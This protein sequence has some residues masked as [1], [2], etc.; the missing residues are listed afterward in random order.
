MSAPKVVLVRTAVAVRASPGRCLCDKNGDGH[1]VSISDAVAIS[2][3][4]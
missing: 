3:E 2:C 4:N 1:G